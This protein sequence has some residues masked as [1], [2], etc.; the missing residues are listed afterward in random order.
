MQWRF[1]IQGHPLSEDE[2]I[3]G[4]ME[5]QSQTSQ[6]RMFPHLFLFLLIFQCPLNFGSALYSIDNCADGNSSVNYLYVDRIKIQSDN[7]EKLTSGVTATITATVRPYSGSHIDFFYT[8]NGEYCSIIYILN[9]PLP[10]IYFNTGCWRISKL[11]AMAI[12]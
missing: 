9:F 7:G 2:E 11:S 8:D 4:I 1:V 3:M 5:K 10:S 12:D 6:I